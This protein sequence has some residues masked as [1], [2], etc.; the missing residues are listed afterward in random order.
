MWRILYNVI[1][2]PLIRLAAQ[3]IS[4]QNSKF[5]RA[6]RGRKG[7][8]ERLQTAVDRFQPQSP[9]IWIHAASMGEFEHAKPII[10]E[11]K[12]RFPKSSL[13]L[14]FFSPSAHN[15]VSSFPGIDVIE[16]LPI[17]SRKEVKR[18]YEILKPTI[19][20]IVKHDSWPNLCWLAHDRNI[21]LFLVDASLPKNSNRL[22]IPL[23]SQSVY[24]AFHEILSV[25]PDNAIR[26]E[27]LIHDK[28][29]I[30]VMGDTRYDQ[31][32][33]R[34]QKAKE[35]TIIPANILKGKTVII[36]GSN[37]PEDDQHLLPV[38]KKLFSDQ[39]NLVAI[40][41][42]HEIEERQYQSI[43]HELI[44]VI[45]LSNIQQYRGQRAILV[46]RIGV[47]AGLYSIGHLAYVGGAFSTGVHSVM[48]PAVFGLPVFTGPKI[49]NSHE[50]GELVSR[51]AAFVI[52]TP[53][54][55]L[56]HW[57]ELLSNETKR[58]QIGKRSSDFVHQNLGATRWLVDHLE[59]F[60]QK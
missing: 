30:K 55:L 6:I 40:L 35:E 1:A 38:L 43:E 58:V 46:D 27:L 60:L 32:Y 36:T 13:V 52:R 31:V 25:S 12:S 49:E 24:Q 10:G 22:R 16:Y 50:A 57:T 3:I 29:K 33:S 28:S 8:K 53:G 9:I 20:L 18:F 47:L 54:E 26:F 21:P 5:R 19:G 11:L 4:L 39:K 34:S 48:E 45:R 51:G 44:D 23:F 15:H 59:P 7:W 56:E 14:T 37:W 2:F 42:P 17:D 41:V